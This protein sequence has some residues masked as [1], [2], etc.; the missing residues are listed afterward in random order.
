MAEVD[1]TWPYPGARWWKFDFH[2][3]TPAS[4]DYGKGPGQATLMQIT[5]DDWLLQFMRAGVDCVAVTDHNS[6]EWIDRLKEA[7]EA[8]K[9]VKAEG[10]RP[11][12]LFPGVEITVNG[13]IHVLA[14]FDGDRSGSDIAALLGAVGYRGGRGACDSAAESAP[15]SVIEA[16]VEAGGIPVPA[17]VDA[18]SGLW[19][20][21][22]NTLAPILD[23]DVLLAG[24]VSDPSS[25]PPELY[26]QKRLNWALVLGSD[27]H[28]PDGVEGARYPGSQYT[29]DQDGETFDRGAAAC[30]DRRQWTVH[31]AKR[32]LRA[33]R[34]GRPSQTYR[35]G[36]RDS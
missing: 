5:P 30:V 32:R 4:H 20:I 16:I 36:G 13:G 21:P 1:G 8:K 18:P 14:V 26:R 3:H 2:T 28:H 6:G 24:E 15:I 19:R 22:G 34:S 35:R 27:S 17:H 31:P 9:L 11:L 7:L 10:F 25:T 29:V 12:H 33:V 23:A